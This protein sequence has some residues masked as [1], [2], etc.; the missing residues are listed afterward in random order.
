MPT[1]PRADDLNR[2]IPSGQP[3]IATYSTR[4]VGAGGE[5]LA[6]VISDVAVQAQER[7]V[8]YEMAQAESEFLTAK[9]QL[10][11]AF[12]EDPDYGTIPDRYGTGITAAAGQAAARISS[13]RAREQF[14]IRIQPTIAGGN[15]RATGLAQAK[16]KDYQRAYVDEQLVNA[17][18]AVLNGDVGDATE[19]TQSL[20]DSAVELGYFTAEEAGSTLRAWQND[21]VTSK[22]ETMEPQARL[23]A[24]E[25]PW[26]QSV[27]ADARARLSKD[28]KSLLVQG[29]AQSAV[30]SYMTG[31][32]DQSAALERARAITDSVEREATTR[33]LDYQ[34]AQRDRAERE[35]QDNLSQEFY[36]PVREGALRVLDIPS[37]QRSAMSPAVLENLYAAEAR[38]DAPGPKRPSDRTVLD[39]LH[40][41]KAL[42]DGSEEDLRRYFQE[43]SSSLDTTDFNLWSKA[44]TEGMIPIEV[45]AVLSMQNRIKDYSAGTFSSKNAQEEATR[46]LTGK[47]DSWYREFQRANGKTPSPED[48]IEYFDFSV[49]EYDKGGWFGGTAPL[50]SLNDEQKVNAVTTI[51]EDDPVG[52]DLMLQV[53]GTDDPDV[54]SL[55][56]AYRIYALD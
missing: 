20:L 37:A 27:P 26:A 36:M 32:L 24:L 42:G 39:T 35:V 46:T 44:T 17:R 49:T 40:S 30:D 23:D 8:N 22:L 51:R 50:Y 7:K 13:A 31:G 19:T 11:N 43:N 14:N 53:L 28:A 54:E 10:D 5:M 12:T 15:A 21:A 33:E 3:G 2:I 38:R 41:L 29:R 25:E 47:F 48:Q 55:L 4:G 34:Y 9:V 16:E 56:Q 52:Y 45:D 18:E 6:N 1:L